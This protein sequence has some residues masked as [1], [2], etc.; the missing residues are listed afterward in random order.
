[1]MDYLQ[2]QLLNETKMVEDARSIH[3]DQILRTSKH[4]GGSLETALEGGFEHRC[5]TRATET[6][7]PCSQ[8]RARRFAAF[9]GFGQSVI[10]EPMSVCVPGSPFDRMTVCLEERL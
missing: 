2:K 10:R 1:M 4:Y 5:V 7:R 8:M 3:L 6:D 9:G